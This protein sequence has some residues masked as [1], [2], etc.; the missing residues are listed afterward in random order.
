MLGSL[1]SAGA[2][3]LGGLM[4]SN[5]AQKQMQQQMYLA[6]N[7]MQI[8][9]ADAEKAGISKLYAVGAPS[10][11]YAPVNTGGPLAAGIADAG[12][13]LGTA[14]DGQ[15]GAGSTTGGKISGITQMM[16]AEQLRGL[17]L[18]NDSKQTELSS[19]LAIAT[20]PGAG[21]MLDNE[22][23]HGPEGIKPKKDLSIGSG[24]PNR[25]HAEY[26]VQPEVSLYRTKDGYAPQIPKD[27][28]EA[29]E[30]DTLGRW[31]WNWRNRLRPSLDIE[32]GA[33]PKIDAKGVEW[34]FDP[35]TGQYLP[36][37]PSSNDPSIWNAFPGRR[38]R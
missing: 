27:L 10:I 14:I 12:S 3:L 6:K 19:K 28:Q 20:Q 13:K 25:P 5:S 18:D 22:M 30:S 33:I 36:R 7:S 16:A 26:G 34:F 1:I 24:D 2:S 17:K 29:F 21:H 38:Y 8:K 23:R 11:S 9:A 4:G 31:Q 15:G 32:S 35:I 37:K